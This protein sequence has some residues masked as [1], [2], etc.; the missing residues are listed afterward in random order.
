METYEIKNNLNV[1]GFEVKDFPNGIGAAFDSLVAKIPGGFNRPYYGISTMNGGKIIYIAAALEQD[2]GEAGKLGLTQ[3]VIDK[4][5]YLAVTVTDWR[6]K[7]DQI[8]G[9]FHK[10]FEDKRAQKGAPCV[11]WYKN[12]E[13]M[14]CLVKAV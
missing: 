7:T 1:M 14:M 9:V 8:N 13:E 10:M 4:G 12:D 3:Y 11:E 5:Q 6:K 2:A